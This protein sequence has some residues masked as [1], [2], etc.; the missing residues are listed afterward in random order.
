MDSFQARV[1]S[2]EADA[3]ANNQKMMEAFKIIQERIG[4]LEESAKSL[5]ANVEEKGAEM[6]G[7]RSDIASQINSMLERHQKTFEL[8]FA[9]TAQASEKLE[10]DIAR[11]EEARERMDSARRSL[12]SYRPPWTEGGNSRL[13]ASEQAPMLMA[14]APHAYAAPMQSQIPAAPVPYRHEAAMPV[15]RMQR[16]A[17]MVFDDDL[18]DEM[19]AIPGRMGDFKDSVDSMHTSVAGIAEKLSSVED[20]V[21]KMQVSRTEG[22]EKL[23]DK[24]RMYSES[25]AG[26]HSRMGNVEKAIKDGITPM[27]ETMKILTDAVRQMKQDQSRERS[28]A[29]TQAL[30]IRKPTPPISL[31]QPALPTQPGKRL[32]MFQKEFG[33][34]MEKA[35]LTIKRPGPLDLDDII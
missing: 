8:G 28:Q 12:E 15:P 32:Q 30:P 31:T 17:H 2:V 3:K 27:M 25:V 5:S 35:P 26:L 21:T 10:H 9:K 11:A 1:E 13:Q 22:I 18:D 16:M 29:R 23:D 14:P 24:I 6:K 20:A 7:L 34:R 4:F 19:E 33:V